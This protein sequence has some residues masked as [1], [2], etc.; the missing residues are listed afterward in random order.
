MSF[1]WI[2]L[3]IYKTKEKFFTVYPFF[4]KFKTNIMVRHALKRIYQNVIFYPINRIIFLI[5]IVYTIF[6]KLLRILN[7]AIEVP[8]VRILY[9]V[10]MNILCYRFPYLRRTLVSIK[11]TFCTKCFIFL[12]FQKCSNKIS[13]IFY[14]S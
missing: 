14:L 12:Y 11:N 9:R 8:N 6:S 2:I 1:D 4:S 10:Y 5:I 7:V 13:L 3:F